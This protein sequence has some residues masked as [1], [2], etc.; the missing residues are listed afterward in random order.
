MKTKHIIAN[1]PLYF[2]YFIFFSSS[3][4][5][6]IKAQNTNGIKF[7]HETWDFGTI[8]QGTPVTHNFIFTNTSTKPITLTNVKGSCGCTSPTWPKT[9]I[10]PGKSDKIIVEFNAAKEGVFNKSV[11]ITTDYSSEPKTLWIKGIVKPATVTQ[12]Q[13]NNQVKV[14]QNSAPVNTGP[15]IQ[16][17]IDYLNSIKVNFVSDNEWFYSFGDIKLKTDNQGKDYLEIEKTSEEISGSKSNTSYDKF[18]PSGVE[19]VYFM[20]YVDYHRK[21]FGFGSSSDKDKYLI[22]V[23]DTPGYKLQ[24]FKFYIRP[25]DEEKA[26]KAFNHLRKLY[27]APEPI[28]F[29]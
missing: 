24:D 20:R 3:F 21:K 5:S 1:K 18:W 4:L 2:L 10:Q 16:Q 26:T 9:A 25:D 7:I 29:D 28:S 22:L 19:K 8:P 23:Y 6:I 14:T 12:T 11:T 17:T 13:I 27:N 15:T